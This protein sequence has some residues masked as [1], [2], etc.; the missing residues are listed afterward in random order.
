MVNKYKL[1]GSKQISSFRKVRVTVKYPGVLWNAFLFFIC[2]IIL[3][4]SFQASS[5]TR[6]FLQRLFQ[7]VG[8]MN[9]RLKDYNAFIRFLLI[10]FSSKGFYR[11]A[12]EEKVD[13]SCGNNDHRGPITK[14]NRNRCKQCRLRACRIVGMNIESKRYL[15]DAH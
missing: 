3:C 10:L 11:R 5:H 7:V 14:E 12:M 2:F 8:K 4:V 9:S 15:R 13:V 6:R 1:F